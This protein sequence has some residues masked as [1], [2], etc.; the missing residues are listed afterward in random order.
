MLDALLPIAEGGGLCFVHANRAVV[1]S[2]MRQF[3]EALDASRKAC[4]AW[5][6]EPS[7]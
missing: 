6:T 3:A 4:A 2:Q 1:L 7:T 5:E